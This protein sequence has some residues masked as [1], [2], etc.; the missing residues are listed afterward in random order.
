[1][2]ESE[3]DNGA[4]REGMEMSM[5]MSINMRREKERER[6]K[7]LKRETIVP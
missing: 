4:T 6:E 1:M 3:R 2:D 7:I 5:S